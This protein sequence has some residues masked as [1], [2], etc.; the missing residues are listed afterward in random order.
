MN[1]HY[2]NL[3]KVAVFVTLSVRIYEIKATCQAIIIIIII[4]VVAVVVS[5]VTTK[6]S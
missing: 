2:D 4:V 1:C 5:S 6:T 3:C